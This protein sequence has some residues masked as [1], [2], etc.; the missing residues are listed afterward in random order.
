ML[1]RLNSPKNMPMGRRA[2][3]R[4][5]ASILSMQPYALWAKGEPQAILYLNDQLRGRQPDTAAV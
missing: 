5:T 2:K 1:R 3:R 4:F